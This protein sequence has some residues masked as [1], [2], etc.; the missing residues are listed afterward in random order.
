MLIFILVARWSFEPFFNRVISGQ[1]WFPARQVE[2]K[3]TGY[4]G[5]GE[6]KSSI[7]LS[8][9]LYERPCLLLMRE[10]KLKHWQVNTHGMSV[11]L[12]ED[13][14]WLDGVR[15]PRRQFI[16][17]E[18]VQ[19]PVTWPHRQQRTLLHTVKYKVKYDVIRRTPTPPHPPPPTHTH[20]I[21]CPKFSSLEQGNRPPSHEAMVHE[22]VCKFHWRPIYTDPLRH[23]LTQMMDANAFYIGMYRT[24]QTLSLDGTGL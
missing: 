13:V 2:F 17:A 16:C 8:Y 11:H 7:I 10:V 5:Q 4:D 14:R 15:F 3:A 23:P 1:S 24:T 20:S 22:T 21:L 18:N 12:A 19:V 9:S 6:F